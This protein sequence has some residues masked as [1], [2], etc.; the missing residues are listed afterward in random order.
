MRIGHQALT[1]KIES[2]KLEIERLRL[3]LKRRTETI[4]NLKQQLADARAKAASA[5]VNAAQRNRGCGC[6]HCIEVARRQKGANH[7]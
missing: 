1:K 2:S 5:I 4:D 7:A 6:K 3:L